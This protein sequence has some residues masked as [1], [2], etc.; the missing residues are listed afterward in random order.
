ME[1]IAMRDEEIEKM[2]NGR[3]EVIEKKQMKSIDEVLVEVNVLIDTHFFNQFSETKSS[4]FLK[5]VIA[6]QKT[7]EMNLLKSTRRTQNCP[8]RQ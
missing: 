3:I 7:I 6:H 8:R 2:N 4:M 1:R 5:K